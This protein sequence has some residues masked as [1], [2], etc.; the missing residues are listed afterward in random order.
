M[1]NRDNGPLSGLLSSA[2]HQL[3]DGHRPWGSVYVR[4]DRFGVTRYRLVVFPPGISAT[5]RRRVRAARGWPLWGVAVWIIA[6][7]YLSN[8]LNPWTALAVST[9]IALVLAL[10]TAATAGPLRRQVRTMSAA[11]MVGRPDLRSTAERDKIQRLG[12]RLI[13]ADES[14]AEG[15]LSAAEHESV[16]WSVYD[17]MVPQQA[18]SG[19]GRSQE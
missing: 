3:L 2:W 15:A 11:V 7:I 16:W 18:D 14:L 19:A 9:G 1:P 5:E 4:R 17:D 10:I 6:H 8:I 13:R 12:I